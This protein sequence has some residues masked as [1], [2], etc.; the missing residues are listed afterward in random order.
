M[1]GLTSSK[2]ISTFTG[3][4][5]ILVPDKD[6]GFIE[7]STSNA[8]TAKGNPASTQM[9]ILAVIRAKE[10]SEQKG[11]EN[12]VILTDNKGAFEQSGVAEARWLEEGRKHYASLFLE[13]IMNR[14]GYLRQSSRKVINRAKPNRLQ[15]EILR[16]FQAERLEFRL[17]DSMLWRKIQ[18]EMEA[19]QSE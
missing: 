15:E 7:S 11:F 1:D 3:R 10:I 14:A 18:M 5:A 19:S 6:F 9:E 16:M 13:R 2:V 8:V 4:I 12:Y 17:S